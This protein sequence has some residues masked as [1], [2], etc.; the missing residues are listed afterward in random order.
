M[1]IKKIFIPLIMTIVIGVLSNSVL[2]NEDSE[3]EVHKLVIQMNTNS[4]NTQ[5]E[6]ITNI[7]NISKFY[8][9]DNVQIEV[10]AY[11]QGIHFLSNES[12]FIKRIKSLM[13]QDVIFTACGDTLRSLKQ[14][15][16]IDLKLIDGVVVVKNG[17]PR[18][19]ELQEKGYSYLSP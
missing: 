13:M 8:G 1:Y 15:K 5:N 19:M 11:G 14:S 9:I 3:F 2:A 16:N 6:V 12:T 7:V 17:V 4:A 10:V 18:M